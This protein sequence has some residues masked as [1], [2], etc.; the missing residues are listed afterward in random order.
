MHQMLHGSMSFGVYKHIQP[1][2]EGEPFAPTADSIEQIG[3]ARMVTD[4]ITYGYLSDVYVLPEYQG[5]GLGRWLMNS[6]SEVFSTE[7]MPYLR[8]IMLLTG[9]KRMQDWYTKIFGME[10]IAHERRPDIGQDLVFMCARP[11]KKN[12]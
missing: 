1:Q 3:L 2:L 12:T 10:V 6:I 5:H 9:D 11:N 7:N 4:G 8:R